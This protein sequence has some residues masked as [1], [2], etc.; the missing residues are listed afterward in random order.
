[1]RCSPVSSAIPRH[2]SVSL[3]EARSVDERAFP[4]WSMARVSEDGSAPDT[5]LI[6]HQ[7]GI[8]PASGRGTTGPQE[9]VLSVMRQAVRG[10]AIVR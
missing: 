8:S 6:A 7:T 3:L 9:G 5:Y 4:R 2:D 1:V 10:T